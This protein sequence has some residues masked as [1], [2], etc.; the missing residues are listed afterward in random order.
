MAL[1]GAGGISR[2]VR[3]VQGEDVPDGTSR[4]MFVVGFVVVVVGWVHIEALLRC[5]GRGGNPD[6]GVAARMALTLR[7]LQ[8]RLGGRV[9]RMIVGRRRDGQRL[10]VRVRQ[11]VSR[12]GGGDGGAAAVG[13][14]GKMFDRSECGRVGGG[15]LGFF[16]EE[17]HGE[18]EGDG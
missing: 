2:G 5:G 15:R 1:E 3:R 10:G 16:A 18:D 12:N 9:G 6:G 11:R 17:W 8:R 4:V 14:L 13:P 7:A